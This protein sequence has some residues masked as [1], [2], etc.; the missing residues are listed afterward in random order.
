[1]KRV[2]TYQADIYVSVNPDSETYINYMDEAETAIIEYVECGLCVSF[3]TVEFHH[4]DGME[5]GFKV[6]LINYPRFP[7]EPEQ[8]KKQAIELAKILKKVCKQNRVS[9]VCTDETIMLEEDE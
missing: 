6:T 1:M 4:V 3:H 2:P 8:I 5:F 7:Q 9:I